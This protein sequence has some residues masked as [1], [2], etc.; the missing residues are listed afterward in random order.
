MLYFGLAEDL[1]NLLLLPKKGH[2]KMH[3]T[4]F[5]RL[6]LKQNVFLIV[7][8]KSKNEE[9]LNFFGFSFIQVRNHLGPKIKYLKQIY[10]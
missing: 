7:C 2:K 4:L 5:N 9:K 10:F 1:G 6:H 8:L 3:L